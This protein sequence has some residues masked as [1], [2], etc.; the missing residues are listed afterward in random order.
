MKYGFDKIIDRKNTI[1][2]KWDRDV[3]IYGEDISQMWVADMDFSCPKE[4]EEAIIKRAS[5]PIYGYTFVKDE[6]RQLVVDRIKKLYGWEIKKEWIVFI[7]GVVDGIASSVQLLTKEGEGVMIQEPVYHPFN[8][9][10]RALNR[11]KIVN[12]LKLEK[13]K[14]VMDLEKLEKSIK[15][16]NPKLAILCSPHNP[17]GRVWTKEELIEYGNL[18]I[19]NDITIVSDEIHSDII[20]KGYKHTCFGSISEKFAQNSI[21]LMAPSKTFNVAG[22]CQA[23]AIVA[24]D[25][26]RGKF[27]AIREG[28]NW[29]NVFG[30]ISLETCYKYGEDYQRQLIEYLEGN[31]NFIEKF[32]AENLPK[33]KMIRP[34]GTYLLWLDMRRLGLEEEELL[35]IIINKARVRFNEG[36]KFGNCGEG[37]MRVNIGCPRSYIEEAMNRLAKTLN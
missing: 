30:I 23:F 31:I 13:T 18:C 11:E 8:K 28:M 4:V 33:V 24:N 16:Q 6:V 1:S 14:Y 21:I 12:E 9:V 19:E 27:E 32:L 7:P 34:E 26:L 22:L 3:E 15:E 36:S 37:F 17:V 10:I 25:E 35:D 29:G 20:Y 2:T 5:H